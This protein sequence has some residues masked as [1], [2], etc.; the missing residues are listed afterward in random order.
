MWSETDVAYVDLKKNV[1][2]NIWTLISVYLS[3]SHAAWPNHEPVGTHVAYATISVWSDHQRPLP[4]GY[5][6]HRSPTL[7][8]RMDREPKMVWDAHTDTHIAAITVTSICVCVAH[9]EDFM[10]ENVE[11][12]PQ[13]R[14]LFDQAISTL[15]TLAQQNSNVVDRMKLMQIG[16]KM[17]R[18]RMLSSQTCSHLVLNNH[19]SLCACFYRLF[20]TS[21]W[22]LQSWSRT[23]SEMKMPWSTW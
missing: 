11:Q 5:L 4:A 12:E 13:A 17:V 10:L 8:G 6:P 20:V 22:S 2:K 15:Q 16:R 9:R 23:S 3:C 18:K 19:L 21:L 7:P 1:N 14:I